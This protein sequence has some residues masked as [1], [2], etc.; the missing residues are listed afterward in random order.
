MMNHPFGPNMDLEETEMMNNECHN[1]PSQ[2]LL[3]SL[4]DDRSTLE[5]TSSL[6]L[7]MKEEGCLLD[8]EKEK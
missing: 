6:F 8:R 7:Q 1:S 2:A 3:T 4:I 5:F